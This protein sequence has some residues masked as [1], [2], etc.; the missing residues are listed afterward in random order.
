MEVVCVSTLNSFE[1]EVGKKV[2]V[3]HKER[4]VKSI[5]LSDLGVT[6]FFDDQEIPC[7][8]IPV[9]AVEVVIFKNSGNYNFG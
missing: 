6:V 1:Y 7:V 4:M 9:S 8:R 3:F 5:T 2:N